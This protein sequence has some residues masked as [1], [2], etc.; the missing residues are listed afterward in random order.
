MIKE[1]IKKASERNDLSRAEIKEAFD[2]IMQGRA[3]GAQIAAL[4]AIMK[5]KG[6]TSE[7]ITGAAESMRS[8]AA[9]VSPKVREELLDVVGTGGDCK[10]TFNISTC[11][12]IVAAASGCRVAKH[13][14]RAVSSGCGAADVL[15]KLGVNINAGNKKNAELIEKIGIAFMFAPMHHPA[16]K[17]AAG[18]RKEMGIRTIFNILGP[19]TNPAKAQT[20]LLGVFDGALAEKLADALKGLGI[21]KALV[22][23]GRDGSDEIS[24]SGST[25]VFEVGGEIK[26]YEIKPEDFGIKRFP[27]EEIKVNSPDEAAGAIRAVL[28]GTDKGAKRNIVLLNAGAAIY[29]NGKAG[30][31]KEGII[32]AREAIDSGKA[33]K[34]LDELIKAGNA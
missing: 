1:C 7:E 19:L 2:E 6:E 17:Y 24:I 22:V 16:M 4:L 3:T 5:M 23:H 25:I 31:I 13:G 8:V 32:L 28:S 18:P 34:K 12:A 14:N 10:N 26:K 29:A 20:I 9:E 15:E 11:A 33:M 21:K 27:I 30:S